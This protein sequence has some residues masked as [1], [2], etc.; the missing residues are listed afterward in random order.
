[1][2][3]RSSARAARRRSR[4]RVGSALVRAALVG[5]TATVGGGVVVA[6]AAALGAANWFAVVPTAV[7]AGAVAFAAY[8]VRAEVRRTLRR[9]GK[10]GRHVGRFEAE[11]LNRTSEAA[12]LAQLGHLGDPYPLWFG[13]YALGADGAAELIRQLEQRRPSRVLETGSG[14]STL[15]VGRY[16]RER[17]EGRLVSLEADPEWAAITRS[18]VAAMGIGDHVRIVDA[19]LVETVVNGEDFRWYQADEELALGAPYDLLLID[20]PPNKRQAPTSP[21]YP[22]LPL[23]D[24]WLA[25]DAVILL[26]DAKRV[27]ERKMLE[28][29]ARERPEWRQRSVPTV[30]GLALLERDSPNR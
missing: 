9:A 4:R 26:D 3:P 27:P 13:G 14:V 30:K 19:P 6:V 10:V 25:P 23:L 22:A 12:A 15:I 2:P 16:F 17:G 5:L 8:V 28:R 20:G 29:W 7:L 1:M 11:M 24:R 18:H 21:R